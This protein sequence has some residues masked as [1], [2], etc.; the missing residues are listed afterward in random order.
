M[1][2]DGQAIAMGTN[3]AARLEAKATYE[4]LIHP[5]NIAKVCVQ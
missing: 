3:E 4:K 5:Q 1:F 2:G